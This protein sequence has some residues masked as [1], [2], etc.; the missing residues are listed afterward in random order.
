MRPDF[1]LVIT[2]DKMDP[3]HNDL[4]HFEIES[5]IVTEHLWQQTV[6]N[7]ARKRQ[8]QTL[9]NIMLKTNE[10]LG[11]VNF[12]VTTSKAFNHANP[13]MKNAM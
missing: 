10:K 11:G 7:V 8:F 3:V 1:L 13:S 5:K 4:K 6:F 2:K 9:E 12:T